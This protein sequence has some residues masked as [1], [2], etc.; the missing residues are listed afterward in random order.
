[1][2]SGGRQK[3]DR[4]GDQEAQRAKQAAAGRET[5]RFVQMTIQILSIPVYMG[6]SIATVILNQA[7]LNNDNLV[8][9]FSANKGNESFTMEKREN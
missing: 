9:M 5:T 1:M 4:R 7:L 6:R 8:N 3:V 2:L